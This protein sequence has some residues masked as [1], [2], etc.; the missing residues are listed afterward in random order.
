MLHILQANVKMT[1]IL[2]ETIA[3][4]VII[5]NCSVTW[6]HCHGIDNKR[7]IYVWKEAKKYINKQIYDG[8]LCLIY[9]ILFLGLISYLEGAL[10]YSLTLS[11]RL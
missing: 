9:T 10:Y 5:L 1:V 4:F 11:L 3:G 6:Q 8:I 2:A 7:M